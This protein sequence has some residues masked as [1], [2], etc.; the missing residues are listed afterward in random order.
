M[1]VAKLSAMMMLLL[2]M[3]LIDIVMAV[4]RLLVL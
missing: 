4:M 2:A 1:L 3:V